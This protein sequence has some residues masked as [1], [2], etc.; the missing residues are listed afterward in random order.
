M[1]M[2]SQNN[3]EKIDNLQNTNKNCMHVISKTPL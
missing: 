1:K 2:G 3:N